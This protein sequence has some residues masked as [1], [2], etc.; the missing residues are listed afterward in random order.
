MTKK[1]EQAI[2]EHGENLLAIFTQCEKEPM[3]L[4]RIV[5]KW[6]RAGEELALRQCNRGVTNYE[7]ESDRILHILNAALGN[8]G[9]VPVFLNGDPRGYALKIED[10][11]MRTHQ[12]DSRLHRDWGGYG[13]IAPEIGKEGL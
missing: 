13:I 8:D 10:E 11:Y 12:Q 3:A 4:C 2:R 1:Q 6:E 5:R 9:T 7:E